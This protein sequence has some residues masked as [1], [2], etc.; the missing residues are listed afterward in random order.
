MVHSQEAFA[1][2]DQHEGVKPEP[3]PIARDEE[4][5][6]VERVYADADGEHPAV[7]L[8]REIAKEGEATDQEQIQEQGQRAPAAG[9]SGQ[10]YWLLAWCPI[11]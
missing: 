11:R 5:E 8:E 1:E 7:P 4:H 6:S 10:T 3:D 2:H 9:T